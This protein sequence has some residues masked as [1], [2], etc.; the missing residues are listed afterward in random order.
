[1]SRRGQAL[2]AV[3]MVLSLAAT[4]GMAAGASGRDAVLA[5][6][7]RAAARRAAALARGCAAERLSA[8]VERYDESPDAQWPILGDEVM[9][10]GQW[11][12]DCDIQLSSVNS[13]LD[14]DLA[15][16]ETLM[17]AIAALV[18][19]SEA[20]RCAT[21]ILAEHARLARLG[22]LDELLRG[23]EPSLA[24]RL[25]SILSIR[26]GPVDLMHADTNVLAALPGIGPAGASAIID[27][28]AGGWVPQDV[29]EAMGSGA[30][31][32]EYPA[33]ARLAVVTPVA[34]A[35]RATA[36][37]GGRQV[38]ATEEWR[39]TRAEGRLMVASRVVR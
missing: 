15:D 28:R 9:P 20:D 5:I 29:R 4:L 16:H 22:T 25:R 26:T 33:L 21:I 39:V 37:T 6:Q 19:Q 24:A 17:H 32:R 34:W 31:I 11:M 36:R 13:R 8:L 35:L 7:N 14:I 1:M 38:A 10:Q 3:L 27:R 30:D 12:F 23:V 2:L 18:P